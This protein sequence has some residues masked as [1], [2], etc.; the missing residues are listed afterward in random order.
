MNNSGG[1]VVEKEIY[2]ELNAKLQSVFIKESMLPTT[3]MKWNE[4][5]IME[6]N[7]TVRQDIRR[8]SKD[9]NPYKVNEPGEI[10]SYVLKDCLRTYD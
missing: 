5:Q 6:S 4:E 7:G 8:L 9:L 10:S 1:R 2:K 3:M